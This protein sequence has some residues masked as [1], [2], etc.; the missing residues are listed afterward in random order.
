MSSK[1]NGSKNLFDNM[2]VEPEHA[3]DENSAGKDDKEL[4][5]RNS[6]VEESVAPTTD[7]KVDEQPKPETVDTATDDILEDVR[8]S[9]IEEEANQEQEGQQ[10]WWKRIGRKSRRNTGSL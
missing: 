1:K 2:P 6:Q 7:S 5:Q 9:L 4:V 3:P 8:R 10:K